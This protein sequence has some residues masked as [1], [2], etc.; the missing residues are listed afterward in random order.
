MKNE[1][2]KNELLKYYGKENINEVEINETR[3]I[4]I[5]SI[6][7]KK[8]IKKI[9]NEFICWGICII[10]DKGIFLIGGESKEIKI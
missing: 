9:N 10:E 2:Y 6:K 5:I 7:E 3:R 4:K 8:I 1:K